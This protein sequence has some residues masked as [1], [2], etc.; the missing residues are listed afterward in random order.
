MRGMS[1][2]PFLADALAQLRKYKAMGEA[3]LAQLEPAQLML[4]P[5]AESN[6]IAILVKHMAGNMRSRWTDF[7]TTDGEKSS[8][9]RDAEFEHEPGDTPESLRAGWEQGWAL[10]F[11]AIEPLTTA[12]LA[13]IVTIRGEPHTVLQAVA[14]QLSH[15]AY[16]VGQI[17]YLARHL[18]GP[19][20]R[21]LSIPKGMSKQYEVGKDGRPYD[22]GAGSPPRSRP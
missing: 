13:S 11:A 18:A 21:S 8:R 2:D 16:H 17:V 4:R 14:R 19:R 20:W 5:D 7:L 22:L 10:C 12:D 3:A 1:A 15:Y 9:R 6:S